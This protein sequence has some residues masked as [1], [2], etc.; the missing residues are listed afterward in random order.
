M[1]QHFISIRRVSILAAFTVMVALTAI[2]SMAS[3]SFSASGWYATSVLAAAPKGRY[4]KSTV[5]DVSRPS[6]ESEIAVVKFTDKNGVD[7]TANV[8]WSSS[9]RRK[10]E[11]A[12]AS[13][14]KVTITVN[15]DNQITGVN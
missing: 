13:G 8:P 1:S 6:P 5:N 2:P 10:L 11:K 9:L 7:H 14:D 3:A 15:S 4:P 12:Q